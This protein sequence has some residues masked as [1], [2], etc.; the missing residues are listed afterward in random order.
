L[1]MPIT[2][3]LIAVAH[4]SFYASTRDVFGSMPEKKD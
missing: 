1:L 3:I 2:F 4:G